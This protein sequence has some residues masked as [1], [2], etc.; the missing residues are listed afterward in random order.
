MPQLKKVLFNEF[1][2]FADKR[3]KKL[4]SGSVFQIDDRGPGDI[5][6][7]GKPLSWFCQIFANAISDDALEV[8]L[9]NAPTSD[10]V[11]KW[12]ATN[13]ATIDAQIYTRLTFVVNRHEQET[14]T[15][16]A[17]RLRA[18]VAPGAPRYEVKGY[19]YACPRAATSLE[20]L[21]AALDVAWPAGSQPTEKG[22]SLF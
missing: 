7:D 6:A 13:A 16:L 15:A 18:I 14:V 12:A 2:G 1:D 10:A 9:V 3:I 21:K 20:K 19:K 17:K 4:T 11:E 8:T 22:R 5:G